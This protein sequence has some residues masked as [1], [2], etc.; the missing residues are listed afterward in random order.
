MRRWRSGRRTSCR[1]G[2]GA[3]AD[4]LAA[5]DLV[6]VSGVVSDGSGAPAPGTAVSFG[7][8]SPVST[9]TARTV[10]TPSCAGR[11]CSRRDVR[12][13]ERNRG[14][15]GDPAGR[16]APGLQIGATASS[17]TSLAGPRPATNDRRRRSLDPD[18]RDPSSRGP[19]RNRHPHDVVER[20]RGRRSSL[21]TP[22]PY[23]LHDRRAGQCT[24][25][26]L[27]GATPS[28]PPRPRSSP[29]TPPTQPSPPT[30]TPASPPTP[31]TQPSRSRLPTW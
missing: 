2:P 13:G 28:S 17:Q 19:A 6:M 23:D 3:A 7:G 31:P 14:A 29:A 12:G 15:A 16:N 26:T 10:H 11:R 22:S 24:F 25:P 27:I 18:R 4:A 30:P 20:C 21:A 1:R 9:V 8:G 5:V